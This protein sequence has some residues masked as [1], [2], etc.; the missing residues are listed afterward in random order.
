[1]RIQQIALVA[2]VIFVSLASPAHAAGLDCLSGPPSG[3]DLTAWRLGAAT[4]LK[5]GSETFVAGK[6]KQCFPAAVPACLTRAFDYATRFDLASAD[7]DVTPE[8]ASEKRP[9]DELLSSSANGLEYVLPENIEALAAEKGWLAVRYKS[10]HAG[11]FDSGT[12]SLLMVYVPGDK[13]TPPVTYDRWLNFALPE[14]HGD[15][16]LRPLPQAPVPGATAYAAEGNGTGP[17]L[18][19]TFTMVTLEK[20][21]GP[22]AAK[23]FFQKFFRGGSGN[24]KFRP[25]ANS[26]LGGCYSCH[27]NG[28]RAISPLGY[29]VRE[30]EEQLPETAWKAVEQI[31][32]AMDEGGGNAAVSWREAFFGNGSKALLKPKGQGP[33]VGPLVPL[34]GQSRTEDF[35]KSCMASRPTVFVTDIFGR[36]PGVGN[37]YTLS[38]QPSV[39]WEK[40]RDSMKCATCHNDKARGAMNGATDWSQI[41][42]KILVDQSMPLGAHTNP[43]EQESGAGSAVIDDLTGDERIA[44]ANCLQAELALEKQQLVKW[45]TQTSCQ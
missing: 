43:L 27:P 41:D 1:M 12:P 9:P 8:T 26:S 24:E 39:R 13:V 37:I 21:A 6:I 4:A 15:D 29:H 38:E 16:A 5:E 45:L 28:L 11:G 25:E 35:I 22:Q 18:P 14:D 3:A 10:R 44:L 40:V 36:A 2:L 7:A 30:G 31:N 42:F 34:N 23:V 19:R 17:S 32:A 20:K 33:I